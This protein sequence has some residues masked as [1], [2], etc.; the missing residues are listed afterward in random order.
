MHVPVIAL[1]PFR[2]LV[3]YTVVICGVRD[4]ELPRVGEAVDLASSVCARPR[5]RLERTT[6]F[7]G[8]L[9]RIVIIKLDK[10]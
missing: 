2:K 10:P 7:L 1:F 9:V 8:G 5:N 6:F 3:A 4:R